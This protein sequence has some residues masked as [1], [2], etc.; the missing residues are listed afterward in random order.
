VSMN[1]SHDQL[2]LGEGQTCSIESNCRQEEGLL[3]LKRRMGSL[4][5]T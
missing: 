5:D 2:Q 4:I 1:G 3:E